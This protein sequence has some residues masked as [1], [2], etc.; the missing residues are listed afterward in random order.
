M[1]VPHVNVEDIVTDDMPLSYTIS[2]VNPI[3][4]QLTVCPILNNKPAAFIL[5]LQHYYLSV[6]DPGVLLTKTK[7]KTLAYLPCHHRLYLLWLEQHNCI[8][9]TEVNNFWCSGKSLAIKLI[10]TDTI[11]LAYK[12]NSPA[13]N[14]SFC[15]K[16]ETW[17]Y[18]Q[19]NKPCESMRHSEQLIFSTWE[20][21]LNSDL[22]P[23]KE[24]YQLIT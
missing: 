3:V 20:E 10:I 14:D 17:L 7:P 11:F 19:R 5:L 1:Q 2:L 18:L 21:I 4:T 6:N 15:S 12:I 22:W 24:E 16:G 13:H 9:S 23:D 8:C